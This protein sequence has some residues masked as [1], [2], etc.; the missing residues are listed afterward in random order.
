MQKEMKL[1]HEISSLDFYFPEQMMAVKPMQ[2]NT[3]TKPITYRY[4]E[5]KLSL[6]THI[7]C[8]LFKLLEL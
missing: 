5:L 4:T 6:I 8:I 1:A 3:L 2:Y 7:I